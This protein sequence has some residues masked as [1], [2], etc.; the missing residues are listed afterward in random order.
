MLLMLLVLVL[1]SLPLLL[2]LLLLRVWY[3]SSVQTLQSDLSSVLFGIVDILAVVP[4]PRWNCCALDLD[5]TAPGSASPC[6]V[7]C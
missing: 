4:V 5:C 2:R 3:V 1:L 7:V 6:R